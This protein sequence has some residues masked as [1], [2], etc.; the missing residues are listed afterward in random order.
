MGTATGSTRLLGKAAFLWSHLESDVRKGIACQGVDRRNKDALLQALRETFGDTRSLSSLSLA[1]YSTRQESCEDIRKFSVFLHSAFI[2]LNKCR[3]RENIR[4]EDEACL[5]VQFIEGV[6]DNG[7]VKSLRQFS[8]TNPDASFQKLRKTM[9]SWKTETQRETVRNVKPNQEDSSDFD[10][11][12]DRCFGEQRELLESQSEAIKLLT[13]SIG[14]RN[15]SKEDAENKSRNNL[16][17]AVVHQQSQN[18][19]PRPA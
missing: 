3:E 2:D 19:P 6:K 7:E 14:V 13:Q 10:R 1:F 15:K 9:L 5:K 16:H 12:V 18:H 17:C 8:L 4:L 11:K